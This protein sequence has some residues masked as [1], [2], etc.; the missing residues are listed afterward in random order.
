MLP[1]WMTPIKV[2]PGVLPGTFSIDPDVFYPAFLEEMGVD[3]AEVNQYQLEV[4]YGCMK[5][6]AARAG[7]LSGLLKGLKG[8]T[9]LVRADDGRKMRWNLSMHPKG[10]IDISADGAHGARNRA[11]REMYRRL[12]GV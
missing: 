2:G 12:R 11:V 5:L 7:R 8:M 9:L 4:A 1:N 10:P 3:V 6:D